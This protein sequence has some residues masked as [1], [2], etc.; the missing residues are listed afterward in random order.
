[1]KNAQLEKLVLLLTA[2]EKIETLTHRGGSGTWPNVAK[3]VNL[4]LKGIREEILADEIERSN[5][6]IAAHLAAQTAAKAAAAK[7]AALKAATAITAL[8]KTEGV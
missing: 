4:D 5:K 1:M 6:E 7:A 3:L 2:K 8:T